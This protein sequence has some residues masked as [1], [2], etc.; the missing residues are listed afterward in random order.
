MIFW[1]LVVGLVCVRVVSWI[2]QNL[3]G[4]TGFQVVE[5][6]HESGLS[7]KCYCKVVYLDFQLTEFFVQTVFSIQKQLV[8]RFDATRPA[9]LAG[10]LVLLPDFAVLHWLGPLLFHTHFVGFAIRQEQCSYL[11]AQL[12]LPMCVLCKLATWCS[13]C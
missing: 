10:L 5:L 6:L 13:L 1:G 11:Y 7:I 3:S 9:S 2:F 12:C 4:C 8:F